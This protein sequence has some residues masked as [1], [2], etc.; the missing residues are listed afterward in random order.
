MVAPTP[1]EPD[2][3]RLPAT[4]NKCVSSSASISRLIPESP[5]PVPSSSPAVSAA[6]LAASALTVLLTTSVFTTPVTA[7]EPERL[8]PT[9]TMMISSLA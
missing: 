1:V 3:L 2:A 5:L 6:L 4:F 8:A 7:V 9:D